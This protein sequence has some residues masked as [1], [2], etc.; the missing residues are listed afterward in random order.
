M[1]TASQVDGK[2]CFCMGKTAFGRRASPFWASQH[3]QGHGESCCPQLDFFP[4]TISFA[5]SGGL[6]QRFS[7]V[8]ADSFGIGATPQHR[9]SSHLHRFGTTAPTSATM[10]IVKAICRRNVNIFLFRT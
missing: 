2:L 8:T 5:F 4:F 1:K 10:T 9:H 3:W 6:Q 7:S